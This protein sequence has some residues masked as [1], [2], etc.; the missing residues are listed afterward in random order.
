MAE[1]GFL[2]YVLTAVLLF[3]FWRAAGGRSFDALLDRSADQHHR[4]NRV[5]A[6]HPKGGAWREHQAWM[7]AD[8]NTAPEPRA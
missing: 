1:T 4:V 8:A 7:R 5:I 6:A 2:L 3:M